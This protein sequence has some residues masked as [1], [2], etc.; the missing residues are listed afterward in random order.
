MAI[1]LIS[2]ILLGITGRW[3]TANME[4]TS[5]V[6]ATTV[7][8]AAYVQ[9]PTTA[10]LTDKVDDLSSPFTK[11]NGLSV[12]KHRCTSRASWGLMK[13]NKEILHLEWDS[14]HG[15][16]EVYSNGIHTGS[17]NFKNPEVIKPPV[18]GRIQSCTCN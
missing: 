6:T 5:T 18:L 14:Q 2:I 11:K 10:D 4:I 9:P 13:K 1:V 3:L 16:I 17:I 8:V 7:T 12:K 15:D